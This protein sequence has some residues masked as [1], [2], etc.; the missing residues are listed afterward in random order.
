MLNMVTFRRAGLVIIIALGTVSCNNSTTVEQ[1]ADSVVKTVD[2][3]SKKVWDSAKQDM[4]ELK[5]KV[6]D[7]FKKDSTDK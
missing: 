7:K 2:T 1:K 5:N 4:K 3:V 6:E